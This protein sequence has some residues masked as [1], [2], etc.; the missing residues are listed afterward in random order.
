MEDVFEKFHLQFG[1]RY[2]RHLDLDLTEDVFRYDFF[3]ALMHIKGLQSWEIHLEH[4]IDPSAYVPRNNEKSKRGE[5]PQ[6]DLAFGDGAE[7]TYVEFAMF[8]RN[9]VDGSPI[10]DTENAFKILNDMMRLALQVHVVK[11]SGYFVS[12]ADYTMLGKRLKRSDRSEAFPAERYE[13]DHTVLQDL[14]NLY[15]VGRK[16]DTRFLEKLQQTG[17]T[18]CA[19]RVF[20]RELK[21]PVPGKKSTLVS[22][23]KVEALI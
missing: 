9:S 14:M 20:E 21:P 17:I 1:E 12:V 6:L 3:A 16:I 13:F 4:P 19:T 8:K 11:G 23:W 18:V 10:N 7:R 2:T 15:V 22:A 5:K